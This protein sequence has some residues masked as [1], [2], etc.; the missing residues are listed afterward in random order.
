MHEPFDRVL[1]GVIG[2]YA[3]GHLD[4]LSDTAATYGID[5]AASPALLT[6]QIAG[7]YQ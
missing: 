5:R 2:H 3:H 6:N 7:E 4:V 1:G